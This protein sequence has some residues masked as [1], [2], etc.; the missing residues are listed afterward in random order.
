MHDDKNIFRG[1]KWTKR[2]AT[3]QT[4]E[5]EVAFLEWDEQNKQQ[6]KSGG[7]GSAR[8]KAKKVEHTKAKQA[9]NRKKW[10][11]KTTCLNCGKKEHLQVDYPEEKEEDLSVGSGGL[12]LTNSI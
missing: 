11:A 1:T 2:V 12:R 5:E 3:T 9:K 10:L 4:E 6:K 7:G 8:K